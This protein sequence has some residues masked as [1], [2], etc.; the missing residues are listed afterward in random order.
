LKI[1]KGVDNSARLRLT[2][3]GEV[4]ENGGSPGDLYVEIHLKPHSFFRRDGE[5]V[6]CEIPISFT[7]ACLGSEIEID[8]LASKQK[9]TIPK[10]TQSGD[11]LKI[12]GVGF[13][14]IHGYKTG[15][16]LIQIRVKTPT[17]LTDKEEELL[18]EFAATRGEEVTAKKK[19]IFGRIK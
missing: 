4:G 5:D 12:K 16:Q 2:G 1:P 8:T 18:R 7:Q 3:E 17:N 13:S 19:G 11:I 15:D 9:L 6:I 14:H 10:G